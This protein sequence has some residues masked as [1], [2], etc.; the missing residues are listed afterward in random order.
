MLSSLVTD[1]FLRTVNEDAH[2]HETEVR[3]DLVIS[4]K[5]VKTVAF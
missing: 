5:R 2:Y 3:K 1:K 4:S